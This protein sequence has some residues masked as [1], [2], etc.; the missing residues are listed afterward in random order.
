MPL[1]PALLGLREET[2]IWILASEGVG[3]GLDLWV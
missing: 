3:K 2:R 1:E